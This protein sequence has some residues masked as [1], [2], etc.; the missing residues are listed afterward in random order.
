VEDTFSL[1]RLG[2]TDGRANSISDCF[3]FSGK[4]RRFVKIK[5]AHSELYFLRQPPSNQPV[6]TE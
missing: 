3:N 6:D 1:G 2:T 4:P 5:T